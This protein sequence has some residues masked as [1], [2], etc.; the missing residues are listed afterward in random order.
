[1]SREP[2][3]VVVFASADRSRALLETIRRARPPRL[4]VAADGPRDG[5]AED[6]ARTDAVR[7]L[8][9]K[10]I[11]WPCDV[12]TLFHE[13]NLGPR[14]AF[15]QGVTWFF[16]NEERG[17][18]LEEDCL[19]SPDF[20]TFCDTL[21]E[22]Y[23][24]DERVF[25]I[26]GFCP[27]RGLADAQHSYFFSRYARVWGWASWR[28]AWQHYE[29]D[30]DDFESEFEE[31]S[32]FLPGDEER[33]Y[34]HSIMKRYYAGDIET[35]DYPW[36]FSIWKQRG[37]SIH[38]TR[39]LARNTGWISEATNTHDWKDWRGYGESRIEPMGEMRHPPAVEI[40]EH[41]DRVVFEQD[42]RPIP[43]PLRAVK[44]GR[45]LAGR[46]LRALISGYSASARW[47]R[48][49]RPRA[50]WRATSPLG[51]PT[52]RY[53]AENGLTVKRG[54]FEG[55]EFG[56]DSPARVNYL[57][58]KLAGT[59]EPEVV[60][61]LREHAQG[62]D[63]QGEDAQGE[64]VFLDIGSADGFFLVAMKR[65]CGA[66]SIGFEINSFERAFARRLATRNAVEIEQRGPVDIGALNRLPVGRLLVLCDV[67]GLEED[68]LDP[69]LVPRL[70][71]ATMVVE[72]HE[73]FRPG[74]SDAL[75]RR[76]GASHEIGRIT[77]AADLPPESPTGPLPELAG[78]PPEEARLA[79][80][81]GHS[82]GEGWMTFVPRSV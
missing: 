6:S 61:F 80:W 24:D 7:R 71:D 37:L 48:R 46:R 50:L 79:V 54:P 16:E 14:L 42:F 25:H 69:E 51:R 49:L 15:A 47:Y 23:A 17:I 19:P 11:D 55:L 62:V 18:V 68:L 38:S 66:R 52:T 32:R 28:R 13:R 63:V 56:N 72:V 77:R 35:W 82:T 53:I 3:L 58:A 10:E 76:F 43:K 36:Q 45:K 73:Q 31:V 57:S 12:S 22:R 1:M 5:N 70:A 27:S 33:Q 78:W 40:D 8:F 30:V 44:A 34:W 65:L 81:D 2:V 9:L 21:L 26:G 41:L 60:A 39:N 74:V 29:L 59:Y 75:E 4:Y 67:E 20:F 64:V